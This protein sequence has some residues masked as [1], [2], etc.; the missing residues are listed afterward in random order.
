MKV[1]ARQVTDVRLP[2]SSGG[3]L[4]SLHIGEA[5]WIWKSAHPANPKTRGTMTCHDD[6]GYC[7]PPI[8]SP[9]SIPHIDATKII[10]PRKS[11]RA[12]ACFQDGA[13]VCLRRRKGTMMRSAIPAKGRLM[14]KTQ[15]HDCCAKIPPRTGPII[16]DIVAIAIRIPRNFAHSLT[17]TKSEIMRSFK[18]N[19]PPPPRPVTTLPAINMLGLTAPPAIA[20]PI[21]NSTTETIIGIRRP[22]IFDVWPTKGMTAV[23]A[24]T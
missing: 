21:E 18:T 12:T 1:N 8:I 17:G 5:W 16:V 20:F 19:M 15:R 14:R 23:Q 13:R 3:M 2:K 7:V 9:N 6:Q 24:K 22:N 11:I 10:F 4:G